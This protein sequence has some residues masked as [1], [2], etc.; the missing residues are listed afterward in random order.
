MGIV[1]GRGDKGKTDLPRKRVSKTHLLI[2][3]LG[4]LDEANSF[5]GMA[6]SLAREEIKKIIFTLQKNLLQIENELVGKRK[7]PISLPRIKEIEK[8]IR[9]LEKEGIGFKGFVLPG[10]NLSSSSLDVARTII[11]RAERR[12]VKLKEKNL[13]KNKLILVYLNRLSDLLYLLARKEEISS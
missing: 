9:T 13:L 12:L 2:E 8:I 11:R 5:L 6:K 7:R 10:K 3:A 1:S 4:T